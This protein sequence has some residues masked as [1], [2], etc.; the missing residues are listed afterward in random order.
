ML[1]SFGN[2]ISRSLVHNKQAS[3]VYFTERNRLTNF[4]ITL[5]ST[6]KKRIIE[7]ES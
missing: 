2:N 7:M 6:T 5:L 4:K 3:V 1:K